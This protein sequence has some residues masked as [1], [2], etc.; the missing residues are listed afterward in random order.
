[1]IAAFNNYFSEKTKILKACTKISGI[2]KKMAQQ[3][4][5]RAGITADLEIGKLTA[6]QLSQIKTIFEQSYDH[7]H[8]LRVLIKQKI[9]R[10][11]SISSYR[12]FRHYQ[13]LPCRGQRTHNNA[14]TCRKQ[15]QKN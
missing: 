11:S 2:G 1:M 13:G 15:K 12:G 7:D 14:R 10:L 3:V 6:F 9:N 8:E 5:D 4:L